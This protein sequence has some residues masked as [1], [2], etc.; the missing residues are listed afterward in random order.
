[1]TRRVI[2]HLILLDI[3]NAIIIALYW[4]E[5]VEIIKIALNKRNYSIIKSYP[6]CLSVFF[7][8]TLS[9]TFDIFMF[10][11]YQQR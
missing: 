6:L 5:I 10:T 8:L 3:Q 2:F 11:V 4:T 9:F 7:S 1:M